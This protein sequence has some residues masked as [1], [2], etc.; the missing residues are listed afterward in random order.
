MKF[1]I[2]IDEVDFGDNFTNTRMYSFKDR[3]Q[4]IYKKKYDFTDEI[5][6]FQQEKE[7]P[8]EKPRVDFK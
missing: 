6:N 3:H 4:K 7:L 8:K 2:F 1:S 5:Q